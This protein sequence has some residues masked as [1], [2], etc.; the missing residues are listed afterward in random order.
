MATSI[1]RTTA[2][3]VLLM[4]EMAASVT[5]AS[6][7]GMLA[8]S[9]TH[10]RKVVRAT[11][12]FRATAEALPVVLYSATATRLTSSVNRLFLLPSLFSTLFLI[13]Y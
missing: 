11:P 4:A 1:E 9:R 5:I 10:S 2:S 6:A 13:D 3:E 7:V 12:Y 8:K